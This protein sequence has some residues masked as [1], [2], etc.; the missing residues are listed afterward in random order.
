MAE[1]VRRRRAEDADY[2]RRKQQVLSSPE[3]QAVTGEAVGRDYVSNWR[4]PPVDPDSPIG[5]ARQRVE[6]REAAAAA[7]LLAPPESISPAGAGEQPP[8]RAE[9]RST[10]LRKP[11]QAS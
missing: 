10:G 3:W 11:P 5:R 8:G 4:P 2:E 9:R 6:L 7:A 1:L